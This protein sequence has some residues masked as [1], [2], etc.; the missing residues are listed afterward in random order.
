MSIEF[1]LKV[2][3]ETLTQ[4]ALIESIRKLG[5][6]DIEEPFN[7]Q[8]IFT[9]ESF[10]NSLGFAVTLIKSKK[11]PY[12]VIDTAFLDE[13]FYYT[14]V[15]S[16]EFNKDFE[17]ITSYENAMKIIFDLLSNSNTNAL[18]SVSDSVELFFFNNDKRLII[19]K[20][21]GIWKNINIQNE[22][23]AWEID[24]VEL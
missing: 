16:F 4:G 21:S 17:L 3:K 8:P 15:L 1:S 23:T 6:T 18:L 19:N 22:L 13:D 10:Y 7:E 9:C 24:T 14:Q 2:E 12:N 11:A 5:F 20:S